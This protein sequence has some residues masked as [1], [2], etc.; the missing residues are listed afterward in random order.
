V[1]T[2]DLKPGEISGAWD[3]PPSEQ[4]RVITFE[5]SDSQLLARPD[6]RAAAMLVREIAIRELTE[7]A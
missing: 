3:I 6:T 4:P 2:L 5:F 1:G 7:T